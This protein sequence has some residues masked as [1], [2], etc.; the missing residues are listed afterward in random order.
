MSDDYTLKELNEV[1]GRAYEITAPIEAARS[2]PLFLQVGK[3]LIRTGAF[4]RMGGLSFQVVGDE[5]SVT[6]R[7]ATQQYDDILLAIKRAKSIFFSEVKEALKIQAVIKALNTI[8]NPV[9]EKEKK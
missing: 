7:L 2:G 9:S 6:F 1:S 3:A 4:S 8:E 5:I